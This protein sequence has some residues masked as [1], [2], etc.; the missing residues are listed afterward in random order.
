MQGGFFS[1][2]A[3]VSILTCQMTSKPI[4]R[5]VIFD[6]DGTLVS[7]PYDFAGMRQAVLDVA[8][9]FGLPVEKLTG[10]GVLEAI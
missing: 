10:M 8:R 1:R 4:L 6:L 7:C 9:L 2:P 5:A 3:F